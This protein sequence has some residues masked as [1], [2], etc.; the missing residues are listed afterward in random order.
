[1]VLMDPTEVPAFP[2]LSTSCLC[3]I[4]NFWPPARF[5][6]AAALHCLC[7]RGCSGSGLYLPPVLSGTERLCPVLITARTSP[8]TFERRHRR[9]MADSAKHSRRAVRNSE[10]Y[11]VDKTL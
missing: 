6:A 10:Q 7:C 3:N 4:A 9:R 5:Q 1:M 2:R 11:Q 8:P